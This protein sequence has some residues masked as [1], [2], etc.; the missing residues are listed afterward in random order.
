MLSLPTS[1]TFIT[2]GEFR[3]KKRLCSLTV[4][5]AMYIN[6]VLLPPLWDVMYLYLFYQVVTHS[7]P[8]VMKV[9]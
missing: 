1:I 7:L 3:M 6:K 8:T 5:D 4:Y 2:Y 9:L